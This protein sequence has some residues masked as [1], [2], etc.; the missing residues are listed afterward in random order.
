MAI[1]QPGEAMVGLALLVCHVAQTALDDR[2]RQA[3]FRQEAWA[4]PAARARLSP[5][6]RRGQRRSPLG[7]PGRARGRPSS[8]RKDGG[9][10]LRVHPGSFGGIFWVAQH[11][12]GRPRLIRVNPDALMLTRQRT[13][14]GALMLTVL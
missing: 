11:S 6:S 12:G 14:I 13:T 2:S 9:S 1:M 3:S 8:S 10:Y 4:A 5:W 7:W